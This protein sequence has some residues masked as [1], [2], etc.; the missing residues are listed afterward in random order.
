MG[1]DC[2]N[3]W[4]LPF[5]LLY[6]Q[7]NEQ[8][9][10]PSEEDNGS[11]KYYKYFKC[12]FL[13]LLVNVQRVTFWFIVVTVDAIH[14]PVDFCHLHAGKWY[15]IFVLQPAKWIKLAISLYTG[16]SNRFMCKIWF[17]FDHELR[18]VWS[19]FESQTRSVD[20]GY[21]PQCKSKNPRG[22]HEVSLPFARMIFCLQIG[23]VVCFIIAS[24]NAVCFTVMC[25]LRIKCPYEDWF[26]TL[27]HLGPVVQN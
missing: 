20:F 11:P 21:I 24:N 4:S 16:I 12:Q 5:Y 8:A 25:H 9:T 14:R 3:S 23:I 18:V 26:L 22:L 15:Q 13:F 2:I 6:I 10:A 17:S 19:C 27:K 1:C 7:L